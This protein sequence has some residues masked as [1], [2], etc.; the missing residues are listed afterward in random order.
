MSLYCFNPL[1]IGSS[2]NSKPRER[3]TGCDSFNPLY[4]GSSR[5][6]YEDIKGIDE[7]GFNPLYIGSSRNSIKDELTDFLMRFQSP[8]YRVKS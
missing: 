1:Y 8:L 4:I 2:R 5:N 6:N 3:F 7:T